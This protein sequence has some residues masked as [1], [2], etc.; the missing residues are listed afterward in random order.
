VTPDYS[1]VIPAYNEEALLPATLDA[2]ARAMAALADRPGEVIVVDNGSTDRTAGL[3]RAHGARVVC[4][5][6]RQIARARNS[7]GRASRAQYLIFV[8]ADT[9]VPPRLLAE[10]LRV[11]DSGVCCGGGAL[12]AFSR[13]VRGA[14]GARAWD[15]VS[16]LC[17]WAPGGYLFCLRQAFLDVGGFDERFYAS[18]ELHM[19][20]A[21][22]RWGW[23]RRQRL[24]ILD[25]PALTSPRKLEWFSRREI[26]RHVL[27]LGRD[28]GR[29]RSRETCQIWY[30]RPPGLS[31]SARNGV[32]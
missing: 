10:T 19:S 4:E 23:R 22:K 16:R 14:W 2:L 17:Q 26:L 1:I 28:P 8:D 31:G 32:D 29:L 12:I 18:E 6:H 20:Q 15:A 13:P 24:V 27:A 30:E 3:A 7:G 21:L 9:L 11:L 5:P 25:G